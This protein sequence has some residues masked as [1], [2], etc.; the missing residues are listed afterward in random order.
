MVERRRVTRY[1][2]R[3]DVR[4]KLGP[5]TFFLGGIPERPRARVEFD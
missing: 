2:V 1:G 5:M 4:G 3:L